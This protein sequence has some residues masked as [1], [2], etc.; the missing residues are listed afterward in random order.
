MLSVVVPIKDMENRLQNL[1]TW[2]TSLSSNDL[3]VIFVHDETD[4]GTAE[5]I[6]KVI[7]R[8]KFQ[9][10]KF[11]KGRY[12]G[13]GSA[14]NAGLEHTVGTWVS[15]WDSDDISF[16]D[17]FLSQIKAAAEIDDVIIGDFEIA[18]ESKKSITR[19]LINRNKPIESVAMNPGIWRVIFKK[20]L[21]G[22]LRFLDIRMGE[23]QVF[24]AN[25]L[26]KISKIRYADRIFYRYFVGNSSQLTNNRKAISDLKY[27]TRA[28]LQLCKVAT[29]DHVVF[30]IIVFERQILTGLKHAT[31]KT[32]VSLLR[33]QLEAF[34]LLKPSKSFYIFS[35]IRI[36]LGNRLSGMYK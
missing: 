27:A 6:Q 7:D 9:N 1:E 32:K 36:I 3:E 13:P 23:D 18:N 5:E 24:L 28:T 11:I 34:F 8:S 19:N 29:M 20:D 12:G 25:Y 16:P 31:F 30:L 33:I 17:E 21:I 22:S 10:F 26:L 15:F 2:Y 4:D 35:A 14:R